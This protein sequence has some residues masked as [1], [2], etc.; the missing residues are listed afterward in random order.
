[1]SSTLGSTQSRA[2]QAVPVKAAAA[3]AFAKLQL[4]VPGETAAPWTTSGVTGTPT[5]QTAGTPVTVT[6]NA[7]EASWEV[8]DA[9]TERAGGTSR[10]PNAT[11]KGHQAEIAGQ[12][13]ISET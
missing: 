7:T 9:G 4:L 5:A 2:I 3:E 6:V 8:K 1:M 11:S 13:A 10:D 12:T